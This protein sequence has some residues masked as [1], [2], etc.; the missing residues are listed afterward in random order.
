ML[1]NTVVLL[2]RNGLPI[3]IMVTLL[4]LMVQSYQLYRLKVAWLGTLL[5][6]LFIIFWVIHYVDNI[7]QF[8]HGI[9]LELLF[10][11]FYIAI[12][13]VVLLCLYITCFKATK[14]NINYLYMLIFLLIFSLNG[15]RFFI[16]LTGFWLQSQLQ[17]SLL[18]GA[19]LG[20][21]ICISIGILMYFMLLFTQKKYQ[22]PFVLLLVL[23]FACGQLNQAVDL[24]SQV[25]FLPSYEA[26][27]NTSSLL[28]EDSELGYFFTALL[29]YEATP[30]ILHFIIYF[31][32]LIIPL[33]GYYFTN[34]Q[35]ESLKQDL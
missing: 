2:L 7:A 27:W 13:L 12:Y 25:D 29:G 22:Q 24:L 26:L 10:S 23:L 34:R 18:I 11:S 3:V 35:Q 31:S 19:L 17:V 14:I 21:G 4:L 8:Y 33:S 28:S 15:S 32:A 16:Y 20:L 30:S 1:I 5:L 9:A 6:S